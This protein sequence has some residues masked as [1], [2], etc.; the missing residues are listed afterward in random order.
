MSTL[1]DRYIA[2]VVRRLPESQRDDIATEITGTIEEMVAAERASRDGPGAGEPGRTD[3]DDNAERTVLARLGD[4]GALARRYTGT[5]QYLIGPGV[6]PVWLHVLRWLMPIAGILAAVAGGILYASTTPEPRLG[7]LIG[8][9]TSSV[10]GALMWVFTAWTLIVVLVERSTPEGARTP[11]D[12]TRGW[13][14]GALDAT[15]GRPETRAN[16]VISLVLLALLAA[17]PFMPSTFLYIGHLNDGEPLVAPGIP[18]FWTAGYLLLIGVLALIQVWLL[19]RPAPQPGRLAVEVCADVAFGVFLTALVLGQDPLIHPD[20][21]A[22]DDG[23][24]ATAIR[25]VVVVAIWAIVVWDQV[26]TV[27]AYRRTRP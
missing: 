9:L 3:D 18:T 17:V 13:D 11:F 8:E 1:T 20:L 7:G 21:V 16:A 14:P 10:A 4:P 22:M 24:T 19:L 5:R 27:R 6:Y 23:G 12:I 2:E 25:W 26:E 15:P